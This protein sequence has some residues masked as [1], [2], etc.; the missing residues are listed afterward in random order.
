MKKNKSV[1]YVTEE[2]KEVKKFIFVLIGLIIIIVGIYFFTR[3][4]VTKDLFDNKT[5]EKEYQTGTINSDIAIVGNM[6]N[7]PYEEYYV[8]AFDSEGTKAIEYNGIVSK[9]ISNEKS[10]KVYHIDLANE[11]NKKYVATDENISKEF[12]SIEKLKLGEI[13][14]I[15]VKNKKVTKF[16]TNIDN[17]TKE[18]TVES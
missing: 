2:Q 7:R 16:I 12:E 5:N 8:L 13:T 10:L 1:K 9:Y 11:L 15:K 17:I 3:A 6:L 18:L 4:F 14:L